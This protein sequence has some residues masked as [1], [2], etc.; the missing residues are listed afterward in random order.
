MLTF[1]GDIFGPV[2]FAEINRQMLTVQDV[3][4]LVDN[5]QFRGLPS[6]GHIGCPGDDK[7]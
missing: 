4:K 3:T 1:Q 6:V 5:I 7:Q 2:Q